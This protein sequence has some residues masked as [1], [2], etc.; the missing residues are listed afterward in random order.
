[1]YG[2]FQDGQVVPDIWWIEG[3]AEYV[4]YGYRQL[5]NTRAIAEAKK[6][7]YRLS[8]LF[9]TTYDN[10]DS[11]RIY[12]WGYLAARYM[13]ERHRSDVTYILGR[14][15]V[16]DYQG[17]YNY[18]NYTIGTRYDAD[19]NTWLDSLSDNGGGV[20]E[21]TDPRTDALGRNCKRSNLTAATGQTKYF[22]IYLP[23]GVS[24]LSIGSAGGT[25]NA[26]LYYNAST[27]AGPGA[28]SARSVNSGNTE[29]ITVN[30]PAGGYRFISLY[31]TTAFSGVTVTTRY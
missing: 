2:D 7:T 27:W 24:T 8:T 29:T 30:N 19:F 22:H 26:D 23:A 3:F 14:F 4:S 16:G 20:S 10:S 1:M 25:G 31:A 6:H 9:Q 15:R 18:Y 17:A 21:C 13:L 5:T 11:N 28:F 12:Q